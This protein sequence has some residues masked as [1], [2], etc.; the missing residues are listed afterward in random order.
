M[1]SPQFLKWFFVFVCSCSAFAP[2]AGARQ[3]NVVAKYAL[4]LRVKARNLERKA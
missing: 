3:L 4:E 2:Y 1:G